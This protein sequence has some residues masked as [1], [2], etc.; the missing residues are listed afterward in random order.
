[1]SGF[2]TAQTKV[3]A[4]DEDGNTVT[5]KRPTVAE[6]NAALT[7][8]MSASDSANL[9]ALGIQTQMLKSIIVG[10]DGPGFEGR[11]LNADNI[12]A[13]PAWLSDHIVDMAEEFLNPLSDDEK[14][15]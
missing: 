15:G 7:I 2:F 6:R 9:Q 10:W 3:I 8:G 11:E 14:K 4:V 5:I 12:T 13:L 1:M